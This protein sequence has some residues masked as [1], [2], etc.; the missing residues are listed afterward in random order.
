[1][2][3]LARAYVDVDKAAYQ[4]RYFQ[5]EQQALVSQS[6]AVAVGRRALVFI[7]Q[8]ESDGDRDGDGKVKVK[9]ESVCGWNADLLEL[10]RL[11]EHPSL[12]LGLLAG[13]NARAVA[14]LVSPTGKHV[15]V[16]IAAF[17]GAGDDAG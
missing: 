8:A 14:R 7:L 3:K 16:D 6:T 4:R 2:G 15:A 5:S 11:V 17:F 13:M 9:G 1:M 10:D 12:S